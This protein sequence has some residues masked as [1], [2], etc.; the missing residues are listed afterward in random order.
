MVGTLEVQSLPSETTHS[1]LG[2][3]MAAIS[4]IQV[5]PPACITGIPLSQGQPPSKCDER[6]TT[7]Q[8]AV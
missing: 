7:G 8:R 6:L 3:K 4:A 1:G 2:A 5:P